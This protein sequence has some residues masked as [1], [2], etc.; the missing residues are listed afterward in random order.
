[1]VHPPR[2]QLNDALRIPALSNLGRAATSRRP[3]EC[4]SVV[5][6]TPL[7]EGE[8]IADVF[9]RAG[10]AIFMAARGPDFCAGVNSRAPASNADM[11]R[12]IAEILNLDLDSADLRNARVLREALAGGENRKPPEAA[13]QTWT[14]ARSAAG[15]VTE[16]HLE[17]LG[18]TTYR[19][20]AVASRQEYVAAEDEGGGWHW[21]LP[22]PKSFTFSITSD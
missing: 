10:T 9:S 11:R 22:R 7:I 5:A 20:S 15:L 16:L 8:G 6:D 14:S 12:T 21:H 13:S 18:R 19:G 2:H 3:E 1:M 4:T 17:T